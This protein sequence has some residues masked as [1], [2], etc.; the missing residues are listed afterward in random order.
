MAEWESRV[1]RCEIPWRRRALEVLYQRVPAPLR[2]RLIGHVLDECARGEVD[3]SGLWVALGRGGRIEGVLLTQELPGRAAAVWAP[4]TRSRWGRSALARALVRGALADLGTRGFLLAQSVL[5]ESADPRSARD[6]AAG[7][8]PR[9]T[10]LLRLELEPRTV[11]A[12]PGDLVFSWCAYSDTLDAEFRETLAATYVGSLDMPELEGVRSMEEI[13]QGHRGAGRYDPERW[14]LGRI[15]GE[16]A[17]AAVLI[18]TEHEDRGVW[19]VVYL[20]LTPPARGRGFGRAVV[21]HAVEI[22]QGCSSSLELAVDARNTPAVNLYN[23]AGFRLRD[24]CAVHLAVF[25]RPAPD[26]SR[27]PS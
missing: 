24:R 22:V 20:G 10:E 23:A 7:G 19:E 8:M 2:D 14:R 21:A 4:E 12:A 15:P 26:S 5:D 13:L 17:A 25:G 16:P 6:L 3:L 11:L 1:A 27:G 18:L 9:V